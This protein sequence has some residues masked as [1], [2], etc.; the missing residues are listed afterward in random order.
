MVHFCGWLCRHTF[1]CE[2]SAR[3]LL[4]DSWNSRVHLGGMCV[5]THPFSFEFQYGEYDKLD[6]DLIVCLQ[7]S[8]V[9]QLSFLWEPDRSRATQPISFITVYGW[10]P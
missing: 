1:V 6:H 5:C 10:I 8:E 2:Q 3:K 4:S 7:L 9:L